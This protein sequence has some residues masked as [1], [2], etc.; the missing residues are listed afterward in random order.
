MI[1]ELEYLLFDGLWKTKYDTYK[2][3]LMSDIAAI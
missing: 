2:G 3:I 1:L